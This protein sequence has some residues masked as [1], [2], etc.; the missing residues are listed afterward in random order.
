MAADLC[1]ST[2]RG[3]S[4]L[5]EETRL[6]RL[7]PS[8]TGLLPGHWRAHKLHDGASVVQLAYFSGFAPF[9]GGHLPRPAPTSTRQLLRPNSQCAAIAA[10]TRAMPVREM[11]PYSPSTPS[12]PPIRP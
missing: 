11:L 3:G 12:P 5:S 10:S 9:E 8:S 7:A 2:Y 4:A 1:S 6:P